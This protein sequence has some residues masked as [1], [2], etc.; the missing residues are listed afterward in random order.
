MKNCPTEIL[1]NFSIQAPSRLHFGF[2]SITGPK[3]FG[4]MGLMIDEPSLSIRCVEN[5]QFEISGPGNG[6][7]AKL[8][9]RLQDK[10]H[11]PAKIT[12]LPVRIEIE[13]L[14]PRHSGLGS[15]T[16]IAFSL[17]ALL[18]HCFGLSQLSAQETA[19]LADR[20]KRSA[21]GSYG[22][23]S[24]GWIADSGIFG[25]ESLSRFE[26]RLEFPL[27]WPI[28][29]IRPT[30]DA[31]THGKLEKRA[32]DEL[33][34][35]NESQ[36]RQHL[37]QL[38]RE[39]IIPAIRDLDFRQFS[40]GLYDFNRF[41]G[42]LFAHFQGGTYSSPQANKIVRIVREFGVA[43]V[44]QSSW[45]PTLFAVAPSRELADDL[46]AYLKN[47][48]EVIDKQVAQFVITHANNCGMQIVKQ[49]QKSVVFR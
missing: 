46:V 24:G 4:G 29:L 26:T 47:K 1:T 5:N 30:Q 9:R 6:L 42:E 44:G 10:K 16:Q 13:K 19:K 48:C 39:Q 31:G 37:V 43:A 7:L 28:I 41:S 14:P 20:G 27:D 32:F 36:N 3:P 15:G 21:I 40:E 22:F 12:E 18:N 11:F 8:V 2:Y 34:K 35:V 33:S 38:A 25:E 17:V 49:E 23:F 45:G